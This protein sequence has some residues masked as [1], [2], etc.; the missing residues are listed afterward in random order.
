MLKGRRELSMIYIVSILLG[1][2]IGFVL[3]GTIFNMI[4]N[5]VLA[6][7]DSVKIPRLVRDVAKLG[8]GLG[9][10]ALVFTAKLMFDIHQPLGLWFKELLKATKQL[11]LDSKVNLK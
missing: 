4:G 9:V 6:L 11:S 10:I 2:W 7:A 3:L 1:L 5:G 8:L